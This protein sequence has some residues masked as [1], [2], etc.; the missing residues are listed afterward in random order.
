MLNKL[1]CQL[2]VMTIVVVLYVSGATAQNQN[3][4]PAKAS[5]NKAPRLR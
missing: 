5:D 3:V 4:E 1:L 2:L